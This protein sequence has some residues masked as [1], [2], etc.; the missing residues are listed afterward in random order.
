MKTMKKNFKNEK[1]EFN[2]SEKNALKVYI[3]SPY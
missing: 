3:S 1:K 2:K